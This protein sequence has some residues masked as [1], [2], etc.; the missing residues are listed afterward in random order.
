[1]DS[2]IYTDGHDIKV[3]TR[4]FIAGEKNYLI[5]GILNARSN[6]VRA[7]IGSAILLMITGLIH[8]VS[9]EVF[10]TVPYTT[11]P[12]ADTGRIIYLRFV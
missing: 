2:I 10:S 12:H 4:E 7:K 3:T 9:M 5:D 6:P 11:M 1:M 8:Q